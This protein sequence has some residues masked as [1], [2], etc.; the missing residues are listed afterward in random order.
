VR[1]FPGAFLHADIRDTIQ[2]LLEGAIMEYIA[3]LK[4]TIYT[5]YIW[6]N[7]KGELML[8]AQREKAL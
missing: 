1:D 8:Y 6:R 5:K 3:K 4:P 7:R 2:M